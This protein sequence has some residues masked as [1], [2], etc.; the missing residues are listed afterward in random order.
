[1]PVGS[2]FNGNGSQSCFPSA[3][4]WDKYFPLPR[5]ILGPGV[6]PDAQSYTNVDQLLTGTIKTCDPANLT[7]LTSLQTGIVIYEVG[8]PNTDKQ[9]ATNSPSCLASSNLTI[10]LRTLES[11]KKYRATVFYK[12]TTLGQLTN[13]YVLW[14]YP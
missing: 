6:T 2:F 4:G 9:C 8:H 5:Y 13:V 7:N 3:Q 12:S 14:S 10:D 1:V 11:G